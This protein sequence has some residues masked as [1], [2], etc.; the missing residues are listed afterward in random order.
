MFVMSSKKKS[1]T[2]IEALTA[3][4]AFVIPIDSTVPMTHINERSGVNNSF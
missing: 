2:E 4:H 3:M 1:Y